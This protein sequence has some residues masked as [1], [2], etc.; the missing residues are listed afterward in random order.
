MLEAI[1][2]TAILAA[3]KSGE[4]LKRGFGSTFRIANKEGRNNLVTEFDT[5]S[6]T[7][8]IN[9][10][11]EKYPKSSFLAEES[12]K[13]GL[14]DSSYLRWII[15]PLD[16]TVNFAHSLPIFSISIAA[17]IERETVVGVIY[18]PMLDELFFAVKGKGAYLN[19]EQLKVSATNDLLSS[20][21]VTG[22]PYNVNQNPSNCIDLFVQVIHMGI[23][24]R[25]LGSAALD[26]AY[27]A[28]GRFDGFWEI[29]LNPW[30]VAAGALIVREA[31]GSVT[32]FDNSKFTLE[33]PTIL[34]SNGRIH[35]QLV[36][37]LT[38]CNLELNSIYGKK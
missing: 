8:I 13:S 4:I 19:G 35:S 32:K 28:A 2:E 23:P 7:T 12:G 34:A 6:E 10:I 36:E 17:E 9:L 26:L 18:H 15:D 38:S 5:L 16:G 20:M 21:L 30:D 27:V 29:D 1:K 25:R 3:L 22:F 31:G 11:K 33:S 24:V 37:T 14:E